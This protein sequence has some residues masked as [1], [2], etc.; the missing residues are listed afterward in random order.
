M[1]T[2]ETSIVEFGF[3]EALEMMKKGYKVRRKV[4][5]GVFKIG[6]NWN[7]KDENMDN[8]FLYLENDEGKSIPWDDV[9]QNH[10][11]AEDWIVVK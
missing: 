7:D 5:K 11:L 8:A 10:I 6:L 3:G 1:I 9:S 2:D 4:W